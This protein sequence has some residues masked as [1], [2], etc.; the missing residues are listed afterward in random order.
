MP[1]LPAVYKAENHC[2]D[3]VYGIGERIL[4]AVEHI[5]SHQARHHQSSSFI[6]FERV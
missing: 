3:G 2:I 5:A 4:N 1:L 6:G